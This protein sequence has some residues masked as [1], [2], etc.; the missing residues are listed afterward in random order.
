MDTDDGRSVLPENNNH[1]HHHS[2][3]AAVGTGLVN[4]SGGWKTVQ[5]NVLGGAKA[6]SSSEGVT[7][8]INVAEVGKRLSRIQ[9]VAKE[10]MYLNASSKQAML[11]GFNFS[12]KNND[13][14]AWTALEKRFDE[15]TMKTG[16]LLPS[17]SFGKCIGNTK[18]I[19]C[20][21]FS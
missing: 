5:L 16:G 11:N 1:D 4:K 3:K 10:L 12:G 6:G 19:A 15:L 20:S 17:S 14:K 9:D 21:L 8:T 7:K 13:P 2:D 18:F